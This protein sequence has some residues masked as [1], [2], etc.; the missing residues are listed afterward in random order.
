M[1][2]RLSLRDHS[3]IAG[4]AES[5]QRFAFALD[6]CRGCTVLDAGC[7]SGY[8]AHFLAASG[9]A[10]V[11]AGDV[12][13]AAIAEATATYRHENLRFEQLDIQQLDVPALR[14]RF[15]V[16]ISFETLA[17]LPAPDDFLRGAK[18]ALRAGGVLIVST[19]NGELVKT[20]ASGRPLAE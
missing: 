3:L 14:D 7:G 4:R 1:I 17:H 6:Y 20:D 19:P 11:L 5:I 18:S 12:S 2:E 9:A 15:D 16:I 10:S 8:G 13:S